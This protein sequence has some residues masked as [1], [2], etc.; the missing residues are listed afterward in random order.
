MI[1]W[2]VDLYLSKIHIENYRSIKKLDLSFEKGKNVIVGKNNSGKSNII[3]AIDLILGE[4][5]PTWNKSNNITDNDFFEGNTDEDIFIWCELI[6]NNEEYVDLSNFKGAFFKIKDQRGN[7]VKTDIDLNDKTSLLYYMSEDFAAE[8]NKGYDS[9]YKKE[10]IGNKPYCLRS[11]EEELENFDHFAFAFFCK[12]DENGNYVKEMTFFYKQIHESDWYVC[13]NANLRNDLLQSAIIPSFRDP[14]SQLRI[15]NYTWYGKLL[16]EC[17]PNENPEL[18]N[19]FENVKEASNKIFGGLQSRI[20][21]RNTQI[22]FP[23]TTISFQFNPDTRQDIYKSTLIYVDDGFNTKLEDKGAGIQSSVII[24]LF[25]NYVRNIAHTNGSLLAIEEPELYLHPQGRRVI[26][27]KLD[28]FLDYNKN[29]VIITTHSP[30]FVCTPDDSINLIVVKK[31]DNKSVATNFYFYNIKLKQILIKK[32]NSEMFFADAVILVEGADKYILEYIAREIGEHLKC[33]N[34]KLGKNWLNDYN[35][36][37][38][39]CGG[40]HEFWK[41]AKVLK[42][43][44]IPY[45]VV[46]DFDF[47]RN[48]LDTYF[49]KTDFVKQKENLARLKSQ[50]IETIRNENEIEKIPDIC[51]EIKNDILFEELRDA[52]KRAEEIFNIIKRSKGAYKRLDDIKN[53][54]VKQEIEQYLIDLRKLNIF[55]LTGELEDF[56][57]IRPRRSKEQGVLEIIKKCENKYISDFVDIEEFKNALI[58]FLNSCLQLNLKEEGHVH[59]M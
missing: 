20:C 2:G 15:A 27:D 18:D 42:H 58:V 17:I 48:G 45:L 22:A 54:N 21:S 53:E 40:K 5:S 50:V 47:F 38:I 32:Q 55:I 1:V 29:Q 46:S 33:E 28:H 41:Y 6:K 12:K 57:K 43:I 34:D 14:K 24:S 11:C 30:E 35:V 10:W 37:V 26:S 19:A 39:S 16:K 59:E 7:Y 4:K 25:D 44:N 13:M 3:K 52:K 51:E 36:S 8:L 23:N 56:Y 49:D 31:D 9:K